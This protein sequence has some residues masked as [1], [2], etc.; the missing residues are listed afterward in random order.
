MS[1]GLGLLM[2]FAGSALLLEEG[3][4]TEAPRIHGL[5]ILVVLVGSGLL[6]SSGEPNHP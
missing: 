3:R 2:L 4:G 5:D 6:F 1:R